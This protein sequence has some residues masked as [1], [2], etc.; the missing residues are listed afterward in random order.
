M[1]P[2]SLRT[3]ASPFFNPKLVRFSCDVLPFYWH[4]GSIYLSVHVCFLPDGD[5]DC[6]QF[7]IP[8]CTALQKSALGNPWTCHV[9]ANSISLKL[10]SYF[11][12]AVALHSLYRFFPV[13]LSI[14]FPLHDSGLCMPSCLVQ[15]LLTC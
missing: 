7:H 12:I 3:Q 10:I 1:L 9:R 11:F 2:L 13:A 6:P 8:S 14:F 5:P 15:C 4:K